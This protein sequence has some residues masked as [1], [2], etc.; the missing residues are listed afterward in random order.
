MRNLLYEMGFTATGPSML[1]VDNQNA[2]SVIKHPKHHGQ[3]KQLD[4]SWYRLHDVTRPI[5]TEFT[6]FSLYN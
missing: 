4:L 5:V 2:I 1:R 6:C 3:M